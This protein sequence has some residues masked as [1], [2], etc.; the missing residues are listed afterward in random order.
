MTMDLKLPDDPTPKD[1][2]QIAADDQKSKLGEVG[3]LPIGQT[4]EQILGLPSSE[5]SRETSTKLKTPD[6]SG[7]REQIQ[8]QIEALTTKRPS[9]QEQLLTGAF[10]IL[11][12]ITPVVLGAALGGGTGAA[13][14]AGRGE[15]ALRTHRK[16]REGI[17]AEERAE[18]R[19]EREFLLQTL[20]DLDKF[21]R[22]A[23][24]RKGE[25]EYTAKTD[26]EKQ[27]IEFQNELEK[28]MREFKQRGIEFDQE[29]ELR[30]KEL[31]ATFGHQKDLAYLKELGD[32]RRQQMGLDA[33]KDEQIAKENRKNIVAAKEEF[34]E[35]DSTI[36][37]LNTGLKALDNYSGPSRV[38]IPFTDKT[39]EIPLSEKLNPGTGPFATAFGAKKYFSGELQQLDQVL[40]NEALQKMV[41]M[42]RG[43]SKAIDSDSERAFFNATT[44]GISR[45]DRVNLQVLL[46]AKSMAMKQKTENIK[47]QE[48]LKAGNSLDT[49]ESPVIGKMTSMVEP[50][51]NIVLVDKNLIK[52]AKEDGLKLVDEYVKD[53]KFGTM[54]RGQ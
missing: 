35:L 22:S 4:T 29:S 3:D 41:S 45:D 49:Y 20:S 51:G 27:N 19:G 48:W 52:A 53:Y 5:V 13:L 39:V 25:L 1:L 21:E 46:G 8:A 15:Q 24:Q 9:E 17:E 47:K 31:Y 54:T 34:S 14:G 10:D 26:L 23:E 44:T 2:I 18:N 30:W 16:T 50:N 11:A 32:M 42:F 36:D 33:A 28:Q 6:V 40:S 12:G 37:R 38:K 7:Q 43:M